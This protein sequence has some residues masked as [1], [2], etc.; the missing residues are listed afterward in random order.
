MAELTG[1][2]G[3]IVDGQPHLILIDSHG[4][5]IWAV[6]AVEVVLGARLVTFRGRVVYEYEREA[7]VMVLAEAQRNLPN[8]QI[9]VIPAKEI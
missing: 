8:E 5:L 3:K 1:Y 4:A 7:L 9:R 6:C 2:I